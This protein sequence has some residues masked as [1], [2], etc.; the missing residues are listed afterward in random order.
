MKPRARASADVKSKSFGEHPDGAA[1]ERMDN[2]R[3]AIDV[4]PIARLFR[5]DGPGKTVTRSIRFQRPPK[6]G[7]G[8]PCAFKDVATLSTGDYVNEQP[9]LFAL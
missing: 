8:I 4:K 5:C 9:G 3:R 1:R 7:G 6:S 2:T